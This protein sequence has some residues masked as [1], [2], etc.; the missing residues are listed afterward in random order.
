MKD[1][2]KAIEDWAEIF[3]EPNVLSET[4][5]K[6]WLLHRNGIQKAIAAE[7][8]DWAQANYFSSGYDAADALTKMIG[9]IV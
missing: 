6:N 2:L 8:N 9:P 1:D 5:K 7:R 4:V 3:T